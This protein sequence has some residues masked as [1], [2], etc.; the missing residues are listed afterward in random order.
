VC[1]CRGK[2]DDLKNAPPG[3]GR[4]HAGQLLPPSTP[5][6]AFA[7]NLIVICHQ[8]PLM[9]RRGGGDHWQPWLNGG[10]GASLRGRPVAGDGL[11]GAPPA[12]TGAGAGERNRRARLA[13]SLST[14]G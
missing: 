12:A 6:G 2:A 1:M 10:H 9:R 4:A 7:L 3:V 5:R 11:G 8:R 13:T 14:P